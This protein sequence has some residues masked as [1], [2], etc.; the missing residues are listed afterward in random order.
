MAQLSLYLD[1]QTMDTLRREA[2]EAHT[3]LSK[4]VANVLHDHI[5]NKGWPEG[6]FDLYGILADDDS[7]VEP[8][9]IPW[10]LDAPREAF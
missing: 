10:E 7:F 3:S 6:W 9:E 4:Y 1:D 5:E 8:E 2:A